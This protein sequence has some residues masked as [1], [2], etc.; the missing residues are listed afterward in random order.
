MIKYKGYIGHFSFDEEKMMFLGKVANSH[1]FITFQGKSVSEITLSF[2]GAVNEYIAW[3][4]RF[5]QEKEKI[6]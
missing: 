3:C 4:K 2:H 6:P 1:D 5:R